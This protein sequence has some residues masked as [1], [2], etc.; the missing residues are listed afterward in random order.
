MSN[1]KHIDFIQDLLA[2]GTAGAVSKTASAPLER[3]KLIMQTQ[4]LNSALLRP[5][6]SPLDC[7]KRIYAEEGFWAFWRG[8]MASIYRYFPNHAMN[9]A[10]K[11]L[12]KRHLK[13]NNP[14]IAEW[15]TRHK[16]LHNLIGSG[17]AGAVSLAV[18]HPFDVARTK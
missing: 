2:G 6:T 13:D 5:Y 17:L 4:K 9:F 7:V 14:S 1:S 15:E 11:D 16:V 3:V 10:F 12:Y 18:C 8:N